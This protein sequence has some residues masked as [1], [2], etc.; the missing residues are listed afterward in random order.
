MEDAKVKNTYKIYAI[1]GIFSIKI[2]IDALI[3]E[4]LFLHVLIS[5]CVF[6]F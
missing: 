4:T 2:N 1:F 3:L 5:K 6:Q